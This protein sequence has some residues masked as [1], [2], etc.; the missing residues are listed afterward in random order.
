MRDYPPPVNSLEFWGMR[1]YPPPVN[2]LEFL[3][4]YCDFWLISML[5]EGRLAIADEL[6]IN[7]SLKSLRET[8]LA[9]RRSDSRHK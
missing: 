1:D 6:P 7:T 4:S 3:F 2:S 5:L 9:N 8:R